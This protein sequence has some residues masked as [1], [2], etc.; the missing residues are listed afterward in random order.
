LTNQTIPHILNATFLETNRRIQ[1][2]YH[3]SSQI[4]HSYSYNEEVDYAKELDVDLCDP[5]YDK[6]V[7]DDGWSNLIDKDSFDYIDI[8]GYSSF[9]D[10][11]EVDQ[12]LVLNNAFSNPLF[13]LEEVKECDISMH[14]PHMCTLSFNNDDEF[15]GIP[16]FLNPLYESSLH[17]DDPISD[18]KIPKDDINM[19][20]ECI[21]HIFDIQ[22]LNLKHRVLDPIDDFNVR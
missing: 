20:D 18:M 11:H 13:Q 19:F 22:T 7:Y 5:L 9:E 21:Y 8:Q 15:K 12:D 3:G 14:T 1:P 16:I 6:V 10:L 2:Q 17:Y 4:F